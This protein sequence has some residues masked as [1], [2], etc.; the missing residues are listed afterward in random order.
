MLEK[1]KEIMKNTDYMYYGLRCDDKLYSIGDICEKS[2]QWYQDE[3]G[4]DDCEYNSYLGIW[5]GEQLE[6]TCG[7]KLRKDNID[8]MLDRMSMYCYA[9]HL[10]LIGSDWMYNGEDAYEGIFEDGEVLAILQ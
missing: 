1:I 9:K 3:P 7:V 5:K 4:S 8:L 2:Y 10:Y 6:G